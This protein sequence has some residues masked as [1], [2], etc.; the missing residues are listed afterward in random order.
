MEE[1]EWFLVHFPARAYGGDLPTGKVP[2]GNVVAAVSQDAQVG[3]EGWRE[4][5]QSLVDEHALFGGGVALSVELAGPPLNEGK[6]F[7]RGRERPKSEI[8]DPALHDVG[9]GR[10]DAR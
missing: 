7:R 4:I 3:N 5:D 8:E 10:L 2:V 6:A 1:D 9:F